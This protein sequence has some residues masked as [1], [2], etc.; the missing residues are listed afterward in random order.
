MGQAPSGDL[1]LFLNPFLPLLARS[2]CQ[3]RLGKQWV[4]P[5]RPS[6]PNHDDII[7]FMG[8]HYVCKAVCGDYLSLKPPPLP[9]RKAGY[10]HFTEMETGSERVSDC[11]PHHL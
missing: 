1:G 11:R 3:E 2:G 8:A 5:R 9:V 6:S 4:G 10:P 7:L